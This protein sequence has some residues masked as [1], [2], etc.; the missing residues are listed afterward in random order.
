MS[1]EA[2]VVC[3]LHAT[4]TTVLGG[5]ACHVHNMYMRDPCTVVSTCD[6]WMYICTLSRQHWQWPTTEYGTVSGIC[7]SCRYVENDN[8]RSTVL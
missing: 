7:T 1:D 6:M 3:A 8:V 5:I 2:E 4:S